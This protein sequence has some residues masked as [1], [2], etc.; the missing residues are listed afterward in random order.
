MFADFTVTVFIFFSIFPS[1]LFLVSDEYLGVGIVNNLP[2]CQLLIS[3][4][5]KPL[6]PHTFMYM[7]NAIITQPT[8]MQRK[9]R[10]ILKNL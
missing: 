1:T 10:K 2:T 5:N 9:Y 7:I 6:I 8:N 3:R 4:C